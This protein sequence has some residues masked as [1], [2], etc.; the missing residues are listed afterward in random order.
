LPGES[1]CAER[2]KQAACRHSE[3]GRTETRVAIVVEAKDLAEYHEFP[4]LTAFGRIEATRVI[5]GRSET[6]VHI[7]LVAQDLATGTAG[8]SAR[9]LADREC[10]ALAA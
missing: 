7:C 8:N 4:G 6:D 2:E 9:S 10:A 1:G 3:H 5:D